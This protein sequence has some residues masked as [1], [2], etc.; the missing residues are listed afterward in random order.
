MK[1]TNILFIVGIAST[2][3]LIL[4]K[5]PEKTIESC[6]DGTYF[7]ESKKE[8]KPCPKG[9]ICKAG[10]IASCLVGEEPKSKGNAS[11]CKACKTNWF[12]PAGEECK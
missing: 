3:E 6:K 7:L 5:K 10:L 9:K 12:S 4:P 8:C 11:E 2:Q 1:I